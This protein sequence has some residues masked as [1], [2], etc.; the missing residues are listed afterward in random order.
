MLK[1]RIIPILL[2]KDGRMIK[3]I[4]FDKNNYRDVGNPL[5]T[6][7]IYSAQWADE[8]IFLDIEASENDR[9]TLLDI[10][11]EVSEECFMPLG[12]GG[13]IRTL[14][15]IRVLL[16]AGA[17]KVIINTSAFEDENFI[18]S[19]AEKFGC[20]TIVVSIDAKK[21]SDGVYEVYVRGGTKATGLDP[22]QWAKTVERRGAGEII[23]NSMNNDGVMEGMDIELIKSVTNAV[24]IPVIAVGGVGHL[25]DFQKGFEDAGASAVAAG[26]IFPFTDQN[27]IKTRRFLYDAGVSVRHYR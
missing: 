9:G 5:T 18:T 7:K 3:T 15:D 21:K 12:V 11:K 25:Q 19:A 6:A 2:L 1:K 17:D 20:S 23:I 8:L 24:N 13:G 22:V 27:I 14:D 16:C 26:S 10:V 4:T